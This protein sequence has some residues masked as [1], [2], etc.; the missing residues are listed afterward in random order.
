MHDINPCLML[1]WE[2]IQCQLEVLHAAGQLAL[3]LSLHQ[4]SPVP[5]RLDL[6]NRLQD[7]H[8][9]GGVKRWLA[10]TLA[11]GLLG[12]TG[13]PTPY[14]VQ[15]ARLLHWLVSAECCSQAW[16]PAHPMQLTP[17]LP[18]LVSRGSACYKAPSSNHAPPNSL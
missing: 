6:T 2:I 4:Q 14:F 16:L 15:I 7:I 18:C 17:S 9:L 3:N 12:C 13:L 1:L 8:F 10:A 5:Q 11:C